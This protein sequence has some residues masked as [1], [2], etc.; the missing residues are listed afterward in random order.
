MD[1]LILADLVGL[2]HAL[3]V[4]FVVGGQGVILL[5]WRKKWTWTRNLFFRV[6]HLA[7]IAFVVLE[8]WLGIPCP[9][10]I[11][12]AGLRRTSPDVSFVGYWLDKLLYYQAPDW[13]F[14]AV[15]SLFAGLVFLSFVF[16][17]PRR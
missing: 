15:Y 16:Y 17:P 6:G 9:L 11:I 5:G 1:D 8:T 7:A 12:E 13:V 2:S 3:F 14:L 10:T 4:F